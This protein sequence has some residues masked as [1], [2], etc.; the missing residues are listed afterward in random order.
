MNNNKAYN[1]S[2]QLS[3]EDEENLFLNE[4]RKERKKTNEY[5]IP[6]KSTSWLKKIIKI[7]MNNKKEKNCF[8]VRLFPPPPPLSTNNNDKIFFS[9]EKQNT[10]EN[11]QKN[12][13][14]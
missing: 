2:S 8:V 6:V 1:V 3:F 11:I 9:S 7:F 10:T 14:K 13:T 4:W 12:F 5:N